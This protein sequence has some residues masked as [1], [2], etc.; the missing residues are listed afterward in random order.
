MPEGKLIVDMLYKDRS[1][2]VWVPGF[3]P[4]TFIVTPYMSTVRRVSVPEMRPT[5][6]FG[7]LADRM[8]ADGEGYY[9]IWQAR[10]GL[11]LYHEGEPPVFVSTFHYY[12]C[13][14]EA[15][16]IVHLKDG[17]DLLL[18]RCEE[19]WHVIHNGMSVE[20]YPFALVKGKRVTGLRQDVYGRVC[21]AAREGIFLY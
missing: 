9:W 5:T 15:S 14:V 21:I 13:G 18:E 6:G 3:N 20:E 11:C 1:G 16:G 10:K 17:A 7:L 12:D 4:T 8:V 2:N 19:L